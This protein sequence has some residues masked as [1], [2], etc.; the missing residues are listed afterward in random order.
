M[1]GERNIKP[2]GH[3]LSPGI[4]DV[5]LDAAKNLSMDQVKPFPWLVVI[6]TKIVLIKHKTRC[7]K[8]GTI[9]VFSSWDCVQ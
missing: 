9:I 1:P 4:C 2:F 3:C 8:S 5:V 7:R 6:S